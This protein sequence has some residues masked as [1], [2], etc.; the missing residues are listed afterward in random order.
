[1]SDLTLI[2]LIDSRT[3]GEYQ[4]AIGRADFDLHSLT[5]QLRNVEITRTGI[6]T[7]PGGVQSIK[8][9]FI[10]AKLGTFLSF[11]SSPKLTFDEVMVSQPAFV[12]DSR[13]R[14]HNR[15]TIGQALVTVFPAVE[16]VL[17]H[18]EIRILKIEQGKLKVEQPGV[19]PVELQSIDLLVQNWNS[20]NSSRDGEIKLNI[21]T[22]EID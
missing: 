7:H 6:S 1:S 12:I 13:A 16:S 3:Q 8:I 11:F 21:G 22:Q 9:P 17:S 18:F 15:I 10:E 14:V 5:Y 20:P 4:L 2:K 19:H